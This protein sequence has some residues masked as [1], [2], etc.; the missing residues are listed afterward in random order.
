MAVPETIRI[1]MLNADVPVPKVLPVWATYGRIF[2]ALISAA[3]SRASDQI[4]ISSIDYNVQKGEYPQSL[5]NVDVILITGSAS[6]AYD[7]KEWIHQLNNY[8]QDIYNNHPHIK[9]FGSCFGHQLLCQSLL[10]DHGVKVEKDPK[11]FEL[12]V[13][14]I[15]ITPIF[16]KMWELTPRVILNE[17]GKEIVPENMR[18][19]FVHGDHVT[20]SESTGLPGPWVNIGS[21]EHCA[22]QGVYQPG[23]VFTLQG[24]F[25]F[26]RFVNTEVLKYFSEVASLPVAEKE[27]LEAADR[28]DDSDVAADLVVRFLLEKSTGIEATTYSTTGGLLTPPQQD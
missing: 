8:V 12:G 6:S 19:Q 16:R 1:A 13:K 4:S 23:R 10:G 28:D 14:S 26:D 27:H 20:F 17:R 9:L 15:A 22:V 2:H 5:S 7:D 24:H 18:L 25:E 11:G 21:T 3:A